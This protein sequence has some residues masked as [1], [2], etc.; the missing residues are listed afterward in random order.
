[1]RPGF[2]F[3]GHEI[4]PLAKVG[5]ERMQEMADPALSLNRARETWQKHG[6]SEKWNQQRMLGQETRNKLTD[7]WANHD[8]DND[9]LIAQHRVQD[10]EAHGI[11]HGGINGRP[12]FCTNLAETFPA[13]S[14]VVLVGG[15]SLPREEVHQ[16]A[17]FRQRRHVE[18]VF[19]VRATQ[20]IKKKT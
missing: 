13:R 14:S 16:N 11:E 7:Y 4:K 12:R 8:I 5:Y 6:R 18:C 10:V 1:V 9:L 15:E 20:S 19:G 2:E 3:F 17:P